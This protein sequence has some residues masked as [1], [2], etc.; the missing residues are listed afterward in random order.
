M[1]AREA[2]LKSNW[3]HR[4]LL[5]KQA[6][7]IGLT[8]RQIAYL[9]SFLARPGY[10]LEAQRLNIKGRLEATRKHNVFVKTD[11]YV[12]S[13]VGSLGA[14]PIHDGYQLNVVAGDRI[15]TDV[16]A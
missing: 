16:V 2:V 4:R 11:D 10:E 12:A 3:Y 14:D 5:K 1:F 8:E 13:L 9:E 7:D 15:P 6:N